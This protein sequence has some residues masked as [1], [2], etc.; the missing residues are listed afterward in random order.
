MVP[1]WTGKPGKWE[2]IFQSGKNQEIVIRLEKAGKSFKNFTQNSGKIRKFWHKWNKY[3]KKLGKF[4]SP[5]EW[6]P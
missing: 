1:I 2:S 5:K 6:E 3:W 4:V